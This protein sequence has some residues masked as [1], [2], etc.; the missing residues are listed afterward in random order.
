[1]RHIEIHV[2]ETETDTHSAVSCGL[3]TDP[4]LVAAC[5]DCGDD[6][7]ALDKFEPYCIV[8]DDEDQWYLCTY[9]A[10]PV[11]DPEDDSAY[12]ASL[13][14]TADDD[15]DDDFVVVDV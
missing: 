10:E 9:C 2:I 7:G 4:Q 1:M 6:V 14:E 13:D 5:A 11:T 3:L 12:Y 8:L 15:E